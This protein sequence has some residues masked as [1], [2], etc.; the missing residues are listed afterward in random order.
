[1]V[2]PILLER[3][4]KRKHYDAEKDVMRREMK[5]RTVGGSEEKFIRKNVCL[6]GLK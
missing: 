2:L 6:H 1:M 4:L 5:W 3:K